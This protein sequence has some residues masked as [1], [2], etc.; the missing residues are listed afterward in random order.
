ML[1][2]LG[3]VIVRL[4]RGA[5]AP[6][7]PSARARLLLIRPDHLGDVLLAVPAGLALRAALPEAHIDWLVGSWAAEVVRRAPHAD[8]VITCPFPGFTRR[9][10][11]SP[12]EPYVDLIRRARRLRGRG[13]DLALVLRPDHWWGA[14]LAAAAGIPHRL[15]WGVPECLP[16][17]TRALPVDPPLHSVEQGLALAGLATN[18]MRPAARLPSVE[19]TFS[20]TPEERAR[21][22]ELLPPDPGRPWVAIHPGSG[23][24]L[25]NWPPARWREVAAVIR[26]QA[27]ARLVLTGGEAETLPLRE[28]VRDMAPPPLV[29]AGQTSLGELAAVFER[30]SLVLGG[31]SGPLHLAQ[32][33][34]TPTVR[35]YGPTDPARFGPRGAP[36]R[37]RVIRAALH[38]QPCGDIVAPPCGAVSTPACLRVVWPEQVGKAALDLLGTAPSPPAR[39]SG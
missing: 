10:K 29:L 34:G 27:R 5:G 31:D 23:S 19:P 17:L 38:C 39:G 24:P 7:A 3:P 33:V 22:A 26:G 13:Y 21:A 36:E 28:L 25:K 2:R 12:W 1:R 8:T 9:P 32:A 15:G 20:I 30:C 4:S 11:R 35:V 16:F 6:V 14:M 18:L 37:Q